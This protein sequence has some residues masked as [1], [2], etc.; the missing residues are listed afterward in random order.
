[1]QDVLVRDLGVPHNGTPALNRLN[2]LGGLVAGKGKAG[3]VGVDLHRPPQSLLGALGHAA[4]Q[5]AGRGGGW[6]WGWGA[7]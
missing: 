7:G 4:R 6:G 1:M 5:R 3:A 2:D